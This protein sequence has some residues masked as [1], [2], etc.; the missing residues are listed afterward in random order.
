MTESEDEILDEGAGALIGQVEQVDCATCGTT[1]RFRK[2]NLL[3][4]E[5][6]Y[7]FICDEC[8]KDV[9]AEAMKCLAEGHPEA[10]AEAN[11][12]QNA[13][14]LWAENDD[15]RAE[16]FRLLRTMM[17]RKRSGEES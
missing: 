9:L 10:F 17:E 15:A 5:G 13:K 8:R 7:H 6:E 3:R 16:A 12:E 2:M 4:V 14:A 1:Q 11:D